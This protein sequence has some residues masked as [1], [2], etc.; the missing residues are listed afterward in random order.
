LIQAPTLTVFGLVSLLVVA[1]DQLST[2][3]F[4]KPSVIVYGDPGRYERSRILKR[5]MSRFGA[6][7]GQL[8][9]APLE[10]LGFVFVMTALYLFLLSVGLFPFI[11][12]LELW[13]S[14][15]PP[16]MGLTV[17]LPTNYLAGLKVRRELASRVF[18]S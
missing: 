2:W 13:V 12:G 10:A 9:Y 8:M 17:I 4:V 15:L 16:L 6:P 18:P 11:R 3:Y 14:I 5:F 7:K 1:L